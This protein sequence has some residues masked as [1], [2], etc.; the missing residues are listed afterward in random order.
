MD[1]LI[2]EIRDRQRC[3]YVHPY[4]HNADVASLPCASAPSLPTLSSPHTGS[5][6]GKA[7]DAARRNEDL[8]APTG[9]NPP[10]GPLVSDG[11]IGSSVNSANSA[12]LAELSE[13]QV[14][15]QTG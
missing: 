3:L 1:G 2:E 7:R 11:N 12:A 13:P 8:C 4:F 6:L 5:V 9:S 14:S 10:G 15:D